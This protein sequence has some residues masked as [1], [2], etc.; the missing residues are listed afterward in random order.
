MEQEKYALPVVGALIVNPE[1]KILLVKFDEKDSCYGL[2]GGKIRWGET[3]E[4]AVKREVKE[5]V[6]LDV[7]FKTVLLV[8]EA[9]FPKEIPKREDKHMIFLEC[10]CRSNSSDVNPDGR[11]IAN[12]IWI[13]SKES[14]KL[15]INSYTKTFIE[16]FM[17]T[18]E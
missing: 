1:N 14:L 10:V 8:L 13:D 3:I 12:Y 5:E 11:E 18:C 16:K 17:E 9:I 15:K 7:E 6:G 4:D 2:P